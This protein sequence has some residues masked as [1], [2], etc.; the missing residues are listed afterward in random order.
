MVLV[1]GVGVKVIGGRVANVQDGRGGRGL[2]VDVV[3]GSSPCP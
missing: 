3:E 2:S 1:L